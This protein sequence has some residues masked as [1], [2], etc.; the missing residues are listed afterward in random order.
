MENL[1]SFDYKK[2]VLVLALN[3]WCLRITLSIFYTE[4]GVMF[5][6]SNSD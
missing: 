5:L 1:F 2:F 3:Q 6:H 4:I